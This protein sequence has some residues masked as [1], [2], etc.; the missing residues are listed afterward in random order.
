[1]CRGEEK[2]ELIRAAIEGAVEEER[3]RDTIWA[4]DSRLENGKVGVGMAWYG[5]V[6]ESERGDPVVVRRRGFCTAGKRRKR[7][8]TYQD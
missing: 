2:E 8:S 4:D 6:P 1:M 3:D 5:E 7:G